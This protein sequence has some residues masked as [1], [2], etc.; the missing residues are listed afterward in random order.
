[1]RNAGP[2]FSFLALRSDGSKAN[3]KNG[4]KHVLGSS[5]S[6]IIRSIIAIDNSLILQKT[7]A[8]KTGV[9]F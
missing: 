5:A 7:N 9:C 1:L 8:G 4:D 3:I 2:V 6:H